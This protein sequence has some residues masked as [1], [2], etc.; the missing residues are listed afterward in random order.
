MG[1]GSHLYEVAENLTSVGTV[2]NPTA[3]FKAMG[4]PGKGQDSPAL[5]VSV[6]VPADREPL[7]RSR[8]PSSLPSLPSGTTMLAFSLEWKIF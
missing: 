2:W 3:P 7:T 5:R 8:F 1:A 4:V 6:D